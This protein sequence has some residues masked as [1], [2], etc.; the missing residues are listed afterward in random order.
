MISV[1]EEESLEHMAG[2]VK[3]VKC[4]QRPKPTLCDC[5]G[6]VMCNCTALLT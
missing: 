3:Y 6:P 1:G 4:L 5:Y 2:H